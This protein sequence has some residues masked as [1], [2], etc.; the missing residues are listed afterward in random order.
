MW[1][2]CRMNAVVFSFLLKMKF[3]NGESYTLS[4]I[5]RKENTY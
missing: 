1:G 2:G 3:L 4:E 5:K